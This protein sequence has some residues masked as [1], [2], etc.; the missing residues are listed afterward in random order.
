LDL[1]I[2]LVQLTRGGLPD[3]GLG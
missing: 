1:A 2:F 3:S